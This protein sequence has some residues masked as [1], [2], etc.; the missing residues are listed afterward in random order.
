[1]MVQYQAS[2]AA[3][4]DHEWPTSTEEIKGIT[5]WFAGGDTYLAVWLKETGQMIGFV[6]LSQGKQDEILEFDLG[7]VFNFDYHGQGYA[8]EGCQAAMDH[9]FGLLAADRITSGTAAANQASCQLLQRLGMKKTGESTA[10]FR[11]TEEGKPIAFLGLSFAITR[12][13]WLARK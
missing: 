7:Y 11:K 6:S 13:E 4:Y 2:A 5:K 8:T 3:V 12:D 10:A 9:A 1:M